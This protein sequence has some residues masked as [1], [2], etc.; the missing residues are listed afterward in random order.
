M[1]ALPSSL[2]SLWATLELHILPSHCCVPLA[3][4][5]HKGCHFPAWFNQ[6]LP[7][8]CSIFYSSFIFLFINV[9]LELSN[10]TVVDPWRVFGR[11]G[12]LFHCCFS[13]KQLEIWRW[14]VLSCSPPLQLCPGDRQ[15]LVSEEPLN[16]TTL[17]TQSRIPGRLQPHLPCRPKLLTQPLTEVLLCLHYPCACVSLFFPLPPGLLDTVICQLTQPS[18]SWVKQGGYFSLHG[19]L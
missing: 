18:S 19:Y 8:Q 11:E 2:C 4:L 12:D 1:E 10:F 13:Q 3:A 6:Q 5:H 15:C 16:T 7:H 9:R 17:Q 14:R